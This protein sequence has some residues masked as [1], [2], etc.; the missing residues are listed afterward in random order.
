MKLKF[1]LILLAL[2][3]L[4]SGNA[5][6]QNIYKR[7]S[8]LKCDSLIQANSDNP[9]FVILDVRTDREWRGGHLEGS[10]NRS[11]GDADFQQRLALLP[12]HK[13]FLLHCQSGGRSA[14]AFT[15]MKNLE[16]AEVYEMIGGMNDWNKANLPTTTGTAPKLMLVSHNEIAGD[17]SDTVKVT[18]TNRANDQ[19]IFQSVT[20][21]DE[22]AITH[23]FDEEISIEGAEDYTFFIYHS[24]GYLADDTTQINL[25]SNGGN[26]QLKVAVE[27][28][29]ATGIS[30]LAS[31]DFRIYPNPAINKIFV[32]GLPENRI[33]ELIIYNLLGQVVFQKNNFSD[34]SA[35]A[36]SQLKEGIHVVSIKSGNNIFTQ[37]LLIKH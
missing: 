24:P 17:V 29:V 37:K 8:P 20:I 19:L 33:D 15:K 1:Y 26:L 12:K 14:G 16:F 36:V 5:F 18:I 3:V 23:N 2:I 32:K 22:H 11:T 34:E 13:L 6:S 25:E 35:I 9:N 30:D 7:L 31:G 28:E 10:I 27:D 21:D 4:Q